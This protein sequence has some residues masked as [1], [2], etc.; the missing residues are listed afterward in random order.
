MAA[1]RV[2]RSAERRRVGRPRNGDLR[3]CEKCGG[4]LEFNERYRAEGHVVPAWICDN[5]SCRSRELV[6][7]EAMAVD[8]LRRLIRESSQVQ[9]SAKRTMLKARSRDQTSRKRVARS[10]ARMK[11]KAS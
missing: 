9:A 2:N 7:L 6:R 4:V 8:A 3:P 11:G 5:A 10:A 1:P